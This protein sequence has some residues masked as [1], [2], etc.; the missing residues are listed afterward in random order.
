MQ[1]D[2][3]KCNLLVEIIDHIDRDYLNL[4]TR[5]S[6]SERKETGSF[7]LRAQRNPSYPSHSTLATEET[8]Q[9]GTWEGL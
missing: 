8:N 9:T 4:G 2:I 5:F 7:H 1:N 3:P 6:D